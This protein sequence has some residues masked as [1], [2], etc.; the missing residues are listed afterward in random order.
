[1][2]LLVKLLQ[3]TIVL[4]MV[5]PIYYLWEIDKINSGCQ[6]IKPAMSYATATRIL[7]TMKLQFNTLQGDPAQGEKWLA[8]VE[9]RA[10]VAGYAC[11]IR[12]IGQQIAGVRIVKGS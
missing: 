8:R 10:S 2:K 12:G 4:M 3:F 1:M 6:Q 11:E 5:Y 9:S 7:A